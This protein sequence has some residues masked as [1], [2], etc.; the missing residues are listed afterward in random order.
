MLRDAGEQKIWRTTTCCTGNWF[1]RMCFWAYLTKLCLM[2]RLCCTQHKAVCVFFLV[3]RFPSTSPLKPIPCSA[4][5]SD[6]RAIKKRS[7]F[8]D[9][10]G[11]FKFR[12]VRRQEKEILVS[13]TQYRNNSEI[14]YGSLYYYLLS[15]QK[16]CSQMSFCPSK[17]K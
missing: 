14:T 12:S 7:S 16:A 6:S 8:K 5:T 13:Y 10:E 9:K 2:C 11:F 3:P 4:P 15:R 17:V 1:T